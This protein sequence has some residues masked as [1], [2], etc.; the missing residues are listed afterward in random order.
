MNEPVLVLN[1]SYEPLTVV[2][3]RRA[4]VLVLT[5]AAEMLE[6][7]EGVLRSPS[8]VV[9]SP[10]VVRLKRYI[11]ARGPRVN[12]EPSRQRVLQRDR[13]TC[14]YCGRRYSARQ[15]YYLTLDHVVPR[16]QGGRSIYDNLVACCLACN[17]RK[18]NRTPEAAGM[19]LLKKPVS[20]GFFGH[21]Q[22]IT[23]YAQHRPDWAKYLFFN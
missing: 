18:G 8:I 22:V 17:Q 4:V 6:H 11:R 14:Q 15:A 7:G 3:V 2:P 16:A 13:Y 21:Q 1:A 12:G 5:A 23:Y 20:F 10:S 19:R 9:P